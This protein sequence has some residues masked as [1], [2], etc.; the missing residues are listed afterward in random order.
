MRMS[1]WSSGVCSSD[2]EHSHR[3]GRVLRERE[4]GEHG[5]ADDQQAAH[6]RR[7]LLYDVG[8]RALGPDLLAEVSRA[9][10]FDELGPDTDRSE[11]RSGGKQWCS[12]GR[13]RW[14]PTHKKKLK[15][16]TSK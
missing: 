7:P 5:R 9:Q 6:R 3:L 10:P 1:D 2:L 15:E 4:E 11:E 13:S 12:T 14:S 8:R 16:N